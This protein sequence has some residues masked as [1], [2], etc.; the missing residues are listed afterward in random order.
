MLETQ[1][2]CEQFALGEPQYART[3]GQDIINS[4]P[5]GSIYF[6]GT[7]PGRGLVTLLCKSQE[8]GDPF[9]TITQNALADNLYLN[10]LQVI[11][12]SWIY[13]PGTEDS[14]KAFQ[15]YLEDA[16]TRLQKGKLKLG[17]DVKIID[18]RV[19]V[20]GQVA[21][22]T[23]NGLL[24]KV[25]FEKNPKREFFIEE[26]FAL[27]WMYPHLTPHGLIMKINRNPLSTIP[28]E[29][30][31]KDHNYWSE[32]IKP[33]LGDWLKRDTPVKEVCDFA[34]KVYVRKDL[35]N[36]RGDP[37]YVG[38]TNACA[39]FSKL[40]SSIAGVYAWRAAQS[41]PPDEK[42]QMVAAADFGFRQAYALC[43]YSPEAVFRYAN[44]LVG[45]A[46]PDDALRVAQTALRVVPTNDQMK[47][48]VRQLQKGKL[49]PQKK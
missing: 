36:F 13:T 18:N 42:K 28:A 39:M 31:E 7:D 1:L 10:Y 44:L 47:D 2:A 24:A 49:E 20:S 9:F 46:R 17:E 14:Q 25:I 48:L 15:D 30:V 35:S 40:R 26:S 12:R 16:Q 11:Y 37:H 38:N 33:M 6:G 22:M 5:P 43:P 34:E 21:V 41:T 32:H 4:I 8:T 3:F 29:D 45:E 23:I 19:Q 27:D